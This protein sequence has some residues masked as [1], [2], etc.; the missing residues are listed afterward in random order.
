MA[1][2]RPRM[3]ELAQQIIPKAKIDD[4]GLP[5]REKN[6]LHDIAVQVK[7][8]D[9]VYEEWGFK[10]IS[11]E[12]RLLRHYLSEKVVQA[13]HLEQKFWQLS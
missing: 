6:L 12:D 1:A 11:G 9:K 13:K 5:I 2:V 10:K 7:Q 8:R 3:A 4:P